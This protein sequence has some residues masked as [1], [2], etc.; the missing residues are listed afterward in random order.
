MLD[1]S[2]EETLRRLAIGDER[3]VGLA[4]IGALTSSPTLPPKRAALLRLAA[5]LGTG[6]ESISVAH[7]ISECRRH[8]VSDAQVLEVT[9]AIAP[10]LGS[11]RADE[12]ANAVHNA[13]GGV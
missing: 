2:L 1:P 9:G 5:L 11:V 7:G 13:L 10:V 8:G 3:T 12:A 4:G 6:P